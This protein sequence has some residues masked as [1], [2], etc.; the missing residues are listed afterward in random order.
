MRT[1]T[2]K[3]TLDTSVEIRHQIYTVADEDMHRIVTT[4]TGFE[5]L[6][7]RDGDVYLTAGHRD[8]ND[9]ERR[10]TYSQKRHTYYPPKLCGCKGVVNYIT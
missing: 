3:S 2:Y 1:L 8:W 10:W 6:V 4:D 9:L 5:F 7:E